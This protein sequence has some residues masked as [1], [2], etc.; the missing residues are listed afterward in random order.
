[1]TTE[2]ALWGDRVAPPNRYF[3]DFHAARYRH[4][5]W[6]ASMNDTCGQAT[7]RPAKAAGHAGAEG[8]GVEAMARLTT[9][10][11]RGISAGD[12]RRVA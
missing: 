12:N 10:S 8:H 1:M 9:R 7:I 5:T 3:D 4:F 2:I 11:L 6:I